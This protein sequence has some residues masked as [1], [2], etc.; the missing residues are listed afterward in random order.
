MYG[1][2]LKEKE[3]GLEESETESQ[4]TLMESN[5]NMF[6]QRPASDVTRKN[7]A[8]IL[9]ELLRSTSFRFN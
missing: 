2:G 9:L 8:M 1:L 4:K 3:A 7:P 6:L 5:M